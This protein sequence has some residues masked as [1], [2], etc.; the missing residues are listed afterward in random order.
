MMFSIPEILFMKGRKMDP[1]RLEHPLPEEIQKMTRDETVCKFCG[2]SYLIHNEIKA[3]EDKL[4]AAEEELVFY[5]G[6]EGREEKL[7]HQITSLEQ[8]ISKLKQD[9]VGQDAM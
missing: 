1:P 3:L 5:R 7:K 9:I 4:R 2:V 8:E 6:V